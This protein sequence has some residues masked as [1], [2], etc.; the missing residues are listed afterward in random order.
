MDCYRYLPSH[1]EF[2]KTEQDRRKSAAQQV[3]EAL[4]MSESMIQVLKEAL[5]AK[6]A[7]ADVLKEELWKRV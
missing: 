4:T 6:A 3:Q 7:E 1:E 5:S 2:C